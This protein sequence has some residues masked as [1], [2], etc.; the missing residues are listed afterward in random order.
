MIAARFVHHVDVVGREQRAGDESR[1]PARRCAPTP[2]R[3]QRAP[4][5]KPA[6]SDTS[7]ACRT[8]T[9]NG[10]ERRRTR[11][12]VNTG[13]MY[14]GFHSSCDQRPE[15]RLVARVV[16]PRALVVP[17]DADGGRP[18]RIGGGED[19][20]AAPQ[21]RSQR[22]PGTPTDVRRRVARVDRLGH[23]AP[24]LRAR[25]RRPPDR[26]SDV[27]R[28]QPAG[29]RRVAHEEVRRVVHVGRPVLL[30]QRDDAGRCA[31]DRRGAR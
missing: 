8:P 21:R 1:A 6:S 13:A 31:G 12:P 15:Q 14:S 9:P 23:D 29:Q 17:D 25:R 5:T 2:E 16:D 4:T 10:L 20:A 30:L 11:A 26:R 27:V 24:V 18:R 19:H 22:S 28:A 7:R 3:E